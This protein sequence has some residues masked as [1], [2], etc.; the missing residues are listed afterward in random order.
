MTVI[1]HLKA[2]HQHLGMPVH[3]IQVW[4]P[5]QEDCEQLRF[6]L[7][8]AGQPRD[9]SEI[10]LNKAERSPPLLPVPA[11]PQASIAETYR[12]VFRA[13][14]SK[15]LPLAEHTRKVQDLFQDFTCRLLKEAEACVDRQEA[16]CKFLIAQL[17]NEVQVRLALRQ[18]QVLS[19]LASG[20][21]KEDRDELNDILRLTKQIE[22]LVRT[23]NQCEPSNPLTGRFPIRS[24]F[25]LS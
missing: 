14:S 24:R 4:R 19:R 13:A 2:L 16:N 3:S 1:A 25:G 17:S 5:S 23:I 22:S 20:Q 10:I 15:H 18:A 9:V 11:P 6:A 12:D 21:S 8:H 7:R